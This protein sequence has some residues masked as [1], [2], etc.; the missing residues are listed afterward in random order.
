MKEDINKHVRRCKQLWQKLVNP[1][2]GYMGNNFS[3]LSTFLR[4]TNFLNKNLEK[5]IYA[6]TFNLLYQC[7]QTSQNLREH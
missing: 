4:F 7:N 1:V 2:E 5:K 3:I 6:L